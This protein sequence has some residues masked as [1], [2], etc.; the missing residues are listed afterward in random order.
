M[1]RTEPV[2]AGTLRVLQLAGDVV[3]AAR[4]PKFSGH[5]YIL[6][7]QCNSVNSIYAGK[8]LGCFDGCS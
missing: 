2:A 1:Y 6:Y 7:A 3:L 4:G 5:A 8:Y